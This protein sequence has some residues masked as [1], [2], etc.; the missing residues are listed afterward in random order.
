M[1][2]IVEEPANSEINSVPIQEKKKP[3][4]K[5]VKKMSS[6]HPLLKSP[7][8]TQSQ[9]KPRVN[10]KTLFVGDSI[11]DVADLEAL[12]EA[13]ESQIVH[14]K[15]Y[16]ANYDTVSNEAKNQA[17]F[18]HKNFTDVI[19]AALEKEAFDNIIVQSGS[20]DITNLKTKKDVEKHFDY[21]HQ[22]AVIS[23]TNTFS[24]CENAL[25]IYPS[26]VKTVIMKQI[27][28]YDRTDLDPLSVKQAL[29][30]IFNKTLTDLWL[31][32]PLKHKMFI[33]SHNLECSGGIRQSRYENVL[34]GVYDG[35]H[36]HGSSG[37][38]FYT[39]SALNIL[40]QAGLVKFDYEHQNCS[41]AQY[42]S[43]QRGFKS[44]A[45]WPIDKDVRNK[46]SRD[47]YRIPLKNRFSRLYEENLGNY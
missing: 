35:I 20:V 42:Q 26:L 46:K 21:F 4:P 5:K 7:K 32:S 39:K 31:R 19:G 27:P 8:K 38:K 22:Q 16:S 23:A 29:S 24:A 13:T 45:T 28:R 12:Q 18:P 25:K 34:T 11:S 36:L 3:S 47:T 37:G 43:R 15:A 40:K 9:D 10:P 41:Q 30:E 1:R 33:G 2:G 14:L 17:R 6:S 44:T